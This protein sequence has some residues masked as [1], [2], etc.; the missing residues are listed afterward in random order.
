MEASL[1][2]RKLSSE[3]KEKNSKIKQLTSKTK[4]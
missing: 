1:G 3:E 4:P 2:N